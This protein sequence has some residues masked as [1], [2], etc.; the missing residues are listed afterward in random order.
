M[1]DRKG[2]TGAAWEAGETGG[3]HRWGSRNGCAERAD[4]GFGVPGLTLFASSFL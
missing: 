4:R 3:L 2:F 1:R